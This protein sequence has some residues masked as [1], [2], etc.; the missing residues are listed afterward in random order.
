[1]SAAAIRCRASA[2]KPG[3][4]A[5]VRRAVRERG[6]DDPT[7]RRHPT[8]IGAE[9]GEAPVEVGVE[10][11]DAEGHG[12]GL[13]RHHHGYSVF[14][15][16]MSCPPWCNTSP[17]T[18]PF[19]TVNVTRASTAFRKNSVSDRGQSRNACCPVACP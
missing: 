16:G 1:M 11:G 15:A 9:R 14:T 13:C 12:L 2:P 8:G 18:A 5:V 17:V 7:R 3:V 19:S 4:D 6:V 10:V